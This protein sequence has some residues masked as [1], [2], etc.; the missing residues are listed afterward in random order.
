MN[1]GYSYDPPSYKIVELVNGEDIICTIRD[2]NP[3]IKDDQIEVLSPLKMQIVPK[4][5]SK[6]IGESLN[7]SHWVHPYTESCS[8][9]I[10][11]HSVI[12]VTDVSPGLSRYYEFILRKIEED[13]ESRNDLPEE[14]IY[15]DLLEDMDVDSD[16]I[17]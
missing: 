5:T 8:F 10:P 6:G 9:H 11:C 15:D 17:H 14:D 1:E 12:L 3:N 4:M 16:S 7:L 13:M 2:G